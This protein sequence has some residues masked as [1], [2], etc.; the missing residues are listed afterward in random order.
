MR[1]LIFI[2]L[3]LFVAGCFEPKPNS[4]EYKSSNAIESYKKNTLLG[5]S[6]LAKADFARA[7]K[8]AKSGGDI[9]MIASLYLTECALQKALGKKMDCSKYEIVQKLIQCPKIK[10]YALF[11]K[12]EFSNIQIKALPKRY[13]DFALFLKQK[14][15]KKANEAIRKIDN[16][17]SVLLA[18]SFLDNKELEIATIDYA[19][20]QN[21]FYGNKEAIIQLLKRKI[22][23]MKDPKSKAVLQ[24]EL[25]ILK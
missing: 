9:D 16:P 10:N 21:R 11:L 4:W 19:L 15:Y 18:V 14:E 23:I 24:K 7:L 20:E 5:N 12:E 22:A 1:Y 25:E 8:H 2:P 6:S 13:R 3:L 17:L